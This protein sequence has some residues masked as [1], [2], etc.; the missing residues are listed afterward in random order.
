M[1]LGKLPDSDPY[2]EAEEAIFTDINITPLTDLFLVMLI[3]FMVAATAAIDEKV[4]K[5]DE[6]EQTALDEQRSGIKVN[7]PSGAAQEID[8]TTKT[9]II[10]ISVEN[11]I[12][13]NNN[14]IDPAD[15]QE[16]LRL[17]FAKDQSTQVVIKADRGVHHGKVVGVMEQAKRVGLTKLAIQ[18]RGN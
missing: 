9:I 18:T 3:I 14:R 6:V 2:E 1:A 15:L 10:A 13:V 7:L 5:L 4:K 8:P 17:A 11:E 16:I 12:E